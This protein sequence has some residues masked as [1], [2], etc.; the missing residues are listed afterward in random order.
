M[1]S[2]VRIARLFS[3]GIH[4]VH[5]GLVENDK[6]VI[7]YACSGSRRSASGSAVWCG[8][9]TARG[10]W[11][12]LRWRR[13]FSASQPATPGGSC[14]WTC[15]Q[16]SSCSN[17]YIQDPAYEQRKQSSAVVTSGPQLWEKARQ[18]PMTLFLMDLIIWHITFYFIF[19]N[20]LYCLWL[21]LP[22]GE[23]SACK[24][25]RQKLTRV[26]SLI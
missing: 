15:S 24:S 11:D 2:W 14:T 6:R 10:T 26:S 1:I 25:G 19:L 21:F 17:I 8:G 16:L 23:S 12:G 7:T 18:L 3:K 13:A 9:G 22:R 20:Q 4:T 5:Q